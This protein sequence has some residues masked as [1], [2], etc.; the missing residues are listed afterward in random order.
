MQRALRA[1]WRTHVH[2]E[3]NLLDALPPPVADRLSNVWEPAELLLDALGHLP[4]GLIRLW[5]QSDRGHIVLSARTGA[6]LPGP[7]SWTPRPD[8]TLSLSGLCT[9]SVSD[10][11]AD[12]YLALQPIMAFLD[13]LLGSYAKPG[14][15]LFSEGHAANA[16]LQDAARRFAA[17]S[18]LEYG[19]EALG[20]A[21]AQA[22]WAATL[23]LYATDH[24]LLSTL[25]PLLAKLY[26]STLYAD[27]FWRHAD[28]T[29]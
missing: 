1:L 27:G 23:W 14:G 12:T 11:I 7:Q 4:L 16:A 28:I 18:E 21:T 26:D 10:L 24:L 9:V 29:A 6:Y 13:H 17:L 20:V 8:R 22:Y 25:D 5:Q 19:Y 15:G 2:V 3:P